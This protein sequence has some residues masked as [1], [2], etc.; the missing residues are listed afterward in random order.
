MTETASDGIDLSTA[1]RRGSSR[2][3]GGDCAAHTG[4][5]PVRDS[6]VPGG[7]APTA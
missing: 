4:V 2:G 1:V 5:V 6:E 3:D 7:P